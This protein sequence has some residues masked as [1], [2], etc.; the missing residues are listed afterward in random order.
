MNSPALGWRGV[1]KDYVTLT[2][3]RIISLLLLTT[4][5][6]MLIAYQGQQSLLGFINLIVWTLVGGAL[7]AGGAGAINM[8]MDRDVDAI[9][10]RTK[11]RP[12]P[13][14]RMQPHHALVF[15]LALNLIAFVVL[16]LAANLLS[17]V[18]AMV[19]TLYYVVIYT[20]WLKRT[21]PQNIVIGG[22]AGAI[23]PLVGWAAVR[24][25]IGVEA[26]LLFAIIFY[27]TPPHFWALA[28]LRSTEYARAGIP[29]LPVVRGE[30]ETK[31]QILLYTLLMIALTL[32]LTPLGLAGPVYLVIATLLGIIFLRDA[33]TLFRTPG[34]GT[35]WKLYKYSLLYLAL[36]FAALVI[37]R[38][39]MQ[40][41]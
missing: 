2:T 20:R 23:P 29:M 41:L 6:P 1:V 35:A 14:D 33:Y 8:Y 34:T 15:G 5:V 18:L 24:G 13:N 21:S 36:L 40:L 9:M 28:L 27:W 16:Y 11:Q 10:S 12:I 4:L 39:V 30:A 37:D 19:G 32:V 26:L 25:N 3:P 31:W 7:A 22:A 17:A 38:A